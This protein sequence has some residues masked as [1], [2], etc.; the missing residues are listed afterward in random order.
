MTL[1]REVLIATGVM[2][3]LCVKARWQCL[4]CY[5]T[6]GTIITISSK[7]RVVPRGT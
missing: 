4:T 5:N 2:R 7:V 1:Q 3:L 6:L